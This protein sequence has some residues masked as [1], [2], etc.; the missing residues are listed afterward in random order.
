MSE[1]RDARVGSEGRGAGAVVCWLGRHDG[2]PEPGGL[3]EAGGPVA[4]ALRP[5]ETGPGAASGDEAIELPPRATV[6]HLAN[7]AAARWP[8]RDL[9]L[10]FDV[11]ELPARWLDRLSDAIASES[12]TATASALH[13]R[14]A[15]P[16]PAPPHEDGARPAPSLPR[17]T[18]VP[19]TCL[20]VAASAYE[21]LGP[22]DETL[23][24]GYAAAL[25]FALRA[26]A[27]GLANLL[28]DDVP[29]SAREVQLGPQDES[30]L[31]QRHP[32]QMAAMAEPDTPALE[33]TFLLASVIG[34]PL[35]VTFDARA[36]GPGVGGTQVYLLGLI[37]SLAARDDVRLRVLLGP[38][39][40]PDMQTLLQALPVT[41]LLSYQQALERPD[42]S[43]VVHRPQ[44][45]FSPDDLLLLQPLG[46]R[47][48][49]TQQDLIAYHNPT[50]FESS[51][52]WQRFVRTTRQSL[53]LADHVIFFSAH[54][55]DDAAREDLVEP[56][57][58]SV[59]PLGIA[60]EPP[61]DR[62]ASRDGPLEGAR[63]AET[64]FLLCIGADYQHK[65][66]P[67]ALAVVDELRRR[68]GWDGVLVLAGPHVEHGSSQREEAAVR[69]ERS[70]GSEAV[71]ELGS[72]S[73]GARLWL[74]REA[75]AVIYPTVHEGF[76]LVP[77]EAAMFGVPCLYAAQSSL[78]EFLDPDLATLVPW[79][80]VRSAANAAPL[81]RDGSER[82]EHIDRLRAAA[83]TL[84]WEECALRTI[85]AYRAATTVPLRASSW[86][87]WQALEREREI[88]LLDAGVKE[89]GAKLTRLTEEIGPDGLAL[90]GP[91]RLLSSSDQRTLLALAIRPPIR[92]LVFGALGACFKI[93]RALRR[94]DG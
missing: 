73:G 16:L 30:V 9:V 78:R 74:M 87:S 17:L 59:V 41:E 92:R 14:R 28:A 21:L 15:E 85:D 46:R 4:V 94:R 7:R 75:A 12:T 39:L 88:V 83:E 13:D 10:V 53:A 77:F 66:R 70:L 26:R 61:L 29:V 52:L 1:H 69:A 90:V 43:H 49:I 57:R 32:E 56:A 71:I 11:G 23:E 31:R 24:S 37:Q 34:E 62:L 60:I 38:G 27:R 86:D 20:Y 22:F 50:Y 19:P 5:P 91:D 8:G 44:Q 3:R 54:A 84:S 36:L 80:P 64:P 67:F 65:N 93:V 25:D 72:V 82:R 2:E 45:V 89:V 79:D 48:V 76:G 33:R 42:P 35:S 81:L 18:R 58:C 51:R 63:L 40:Q 68:H 47:L 6:A 55:M